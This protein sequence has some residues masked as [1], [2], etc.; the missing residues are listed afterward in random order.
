MHVRTPKW[1]TRYLNRYLLRVS[2]N[3]EAKSDRFEVIV[4]TTW[5]FSDNLVY[6]RVSEGIQRWRQLRDPFLRFRSSSSGQ[7]APNEWLAWSPNRSAVEDLP[8]MRDQIS[9]QRSGPAPS[10]PTGSGGPP[11]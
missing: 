7:S 3:S 8:D 2:S 6:G 9:N 11:P 1:E 10:A 5:E 4:P